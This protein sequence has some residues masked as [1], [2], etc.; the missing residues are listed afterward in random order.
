[1][2]HAVSARTYRAWLGGLAGLALVAAGCAPARPTPASP[3]RCDDHVDLAQTMPAEMRALGA[4]SAVGSGDTW[5]FAPASADWSSSVQPEGDGYQLKIGMW[6]ATP[7][8]PQ[9]TVREVSGGNAVGTTTFAPT[10]GGLPGPLP[11]T[12]H[13]PAPGCWEIVARGPTGSA[14]ARVRVGP[15]S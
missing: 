10:T 2:I 3:A 13:M 15:A 14:S 6:I 11:S 4:T 8:P 5:Y 7:R 1:M 12:S 9:V